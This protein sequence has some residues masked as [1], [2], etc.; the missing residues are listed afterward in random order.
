MLTQNTR[1]TYK[2]KVVL[3][4]AVCFVVL[5]GA[6][7]HAKTDSSTLGKR[8]KTSCFTLYKRMAG[9][10]ALKAGNAA[11]VFSFD[12]HFSVVTNRASALKNGILNIAQMFEQLSDKQMIEFFNTLYP[13]ASG[14]VNG[15]VNKQQKQILLQVLSGKYRNTELVKKLGVLHRTLKRYL[16]I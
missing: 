12:G 1:A 5:I 11:R 8:V 6:G 2:Q 15:T 7:L 13:T 10:T 14:I 4:I 9:Y 16:A 3:L